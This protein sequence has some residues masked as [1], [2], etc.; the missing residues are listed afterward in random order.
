[1][2]AFVQGPNVRLGQSPDGTKPNCALPLDL[3][4]SRDASRGYPSGSQEEDTCESLNKGG[5]IKK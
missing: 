3:G 5:F 2:T 4:A 1:M